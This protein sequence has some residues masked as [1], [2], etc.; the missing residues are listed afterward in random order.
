MFWAWEVFQHTSDRSEL[1]RQ[2]RALRRQLKPILRRFSGKA[3]CYKYT[4]G[5]AR[6]L[7]KL[8]PAL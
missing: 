3:P 7:L 1:K 6:N 8:W 2:M 4:R 5:M